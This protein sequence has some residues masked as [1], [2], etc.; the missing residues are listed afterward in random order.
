MSVQE[1][2]YAWHYSFVWVPAYRE[3]KGPTAP[4]RQNFSNQALAANV[5]VRGLAPDREGFKKAFPVLT[6][7]CYKYILQHG[8]QIRWSLLSALPVTLDLGLKT[9]I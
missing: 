7:G 9:A 3:I 5:G 6:S 1:G 8:V 4:Q 2:L